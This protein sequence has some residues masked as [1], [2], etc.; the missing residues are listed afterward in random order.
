MLHRHATILP[1]YSNRRGDTPTGRR[2]VLNAAK[3]AVAAGYGAMVVVLPPTSIFMLGIPI[4]LMLLVTLWMLP[5]RDSFPMRAIEWL[6]PVF[7]TFNVLWPCSDIPR[8][9]R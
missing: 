6:F 3:L 7:F 5:D 2:I 9:L 8:S 1:Q 4:A